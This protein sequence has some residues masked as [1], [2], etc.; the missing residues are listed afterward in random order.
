MEIINFELGLINFKMGLIYLNFKGLANLTLSIF[1][2]NDPILKLIIPKC[3][4]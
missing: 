2:L 1:K 4:S 3:N